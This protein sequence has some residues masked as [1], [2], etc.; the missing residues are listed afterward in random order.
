MPIGN[1]F[2]LSFEGIAGGRL[3]Y[4]P[5]EGVDEEEV[6][7]GGGE[8][9]VAV[10]H[11]EVDHP[12]AGVGPDNREVAA[13]DNVLQAHGEVFRR[14]GYKDLNIGVE[15][16]IGLP[17]VELA[18]RAYELFGKILC[19]VVFLGFHLQERWLRGPGVAEESAPS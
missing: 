3:A 17:L 8:A 6:L 10:A 5:A 11:V 14:E 2:R 16:W 15:P 4:D 9:F 7:G 1:Y 18:G 13:E 12:V 19:Y